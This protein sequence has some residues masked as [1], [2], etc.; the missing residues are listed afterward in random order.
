[1]NTTMTFILLGPD[2]P[3]K[4]ASPSTLGKDARPDVAAI[5]SSTSPSANPSAKKLDSKDSAA[6]EMTGPNNES[7]DGDQS[8][9]INWT[10]PISSTNESSSN[11][12]AKAKEKESNASQKKGDA[13]IPAKKMDAHSLDRADAQNVTT[14]NSP[15][16]KPGKGPD[17][18]RNGTGHGIFTRTSPNLLRKGSGPLAPTI[19]KSPN[20]HAEETSSETS[21]R[22]E[23]DVVAS[24]KEVA[25]LD[26]PVSKETI[27]DLPTKEAKPRTGRVPDPSGNLETE[28]LSS[29]GYSDNS[30][31][32]V[33]PLLSDSDPG[34][35]N[36][37]YH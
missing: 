19:K 31:P 12:P 22:N 18:P 26:R 7:E 1:M 27:L 4:E 21:T 5:E 37:T 24:K 11:F 34:T 17:V 10:G 2:I 35:A 32:N 8:E 33:I 14:S 36:G 16:S 15:P 13:D 9:L 3:S 30:K 23:A 6:I 20:I 29:N 28:A 25:H